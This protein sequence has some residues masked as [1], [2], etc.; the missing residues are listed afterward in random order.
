MKSESKTVE[1][2]M[3]ELAPERQEAMMKLRS[4]ILANIPKGFEEGMSYGMIGYC[5]P[6]S[7]YPA[8]YHCNPEQALPFTWLIKK[9]EFR[10]T[11]WAFTWIKT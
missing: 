3:A 10:F 8:G 5:V 4:V 11:T 2:Y 1:A 9:P 7:T 6:K